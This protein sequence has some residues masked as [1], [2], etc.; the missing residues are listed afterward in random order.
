MGV[1]S[2]PFKVALSLDDMEPKRLVI[3]ILG[4][5]SIIPTLSLVPGLA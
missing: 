2:V 4:L 5:I 1:L 3:N